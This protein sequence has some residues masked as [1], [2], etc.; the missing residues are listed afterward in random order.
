[1]SE[2]SR[3]DVEANARPSSKEG[4]GAYVSQHEIGIAATFDEDQI[5]DSGTLDPVY[6]AK[7]KLLN[8]AVSTSICR[9]VGATMLTDL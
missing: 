2:K 7:A 3:N 9:L 1:M 5:I 4:G 8:R 6:E